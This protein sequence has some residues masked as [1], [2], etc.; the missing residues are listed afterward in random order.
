MRRS[1][2]LRLLSCHVHK[3]LHNPILASLAHHSSSTVCNKIGLDLALVNCLTMVIE[4]L[5]RT[6]E[7]LAGKR[8]MYICLIT[9]S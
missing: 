4:A 8:H 2:L 7:A 9:L 3:T 6:Q 1:F 5:L